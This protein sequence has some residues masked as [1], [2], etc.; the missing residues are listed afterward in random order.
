[1]P[2]DHKKLA[3]LGI[4]VPEILLPAPSVD[5]VAWSVIACD[6]HTSDREYWQRVRTSCGDNPS[7]LDLVFPEVYLEDDDAPRRISEIH[8]AMS[9]YLD[10]G[11]LRSHGRGWMYVQ[12][13]TEASGLRQGLVLAVDLEAYDFS[14]GS[15]SLI[16]ATEGT[17]LDRLPPRVKVRRDAPLELPHIMIL[18][19]DR[20][21]KII[22]GLEAISGTLEQAY[23]LELMEGGGRLTGFWIDRSEIINTIAGQLSEL[24]DSKTSLARYGSEDPL[25]FAMG[26]GNHSL[27]TA[28]SVWEGIKKEHAQTGADPA[29]IENHPARYA[30]AEVVNIYSPGLRFEPIHRVIFD[31]GLDGLIASLGDGEPKPLEG[32]AAAREYLASDANGAVFFHGDTWYSLAGDP[33]ELAPARIDRAFNNLTSN[34]CGNAAKIDFIHGWEHTRDLA[35]GRND[36]IAVFFNVIAREE[37]FGYVI[38]HGALPR[39]AFSMGDAEEKRYYFEARRVR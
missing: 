4:T 16:R 1:M 5:P 26:D 34:P 14:E 21:K 6:Q 20:E 2:V 12:R 9:D 7:T 38:R 22:E 36:R 3:E 28:K 23:D 8:K 35:A 18:I 37:L 17:I 25:L 10:K 33:D 31:A 27:A 30:L 32:E 39:K 24:A 15:T 11:Y 13:R 29:E 19:D